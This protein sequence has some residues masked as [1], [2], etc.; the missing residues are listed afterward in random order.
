MKTSN[1]LLI[2]AVLIIIVS[3]VGYDLALRAEYRKGTYK[4]RFYGFDKTTAFSGFTKIDNRAANLISIEVEHG[5]EPGI[6]MKSDWKDRIK[7]SKIG[8]TLV[9]EAA[10][11]QAS[12]LSPYENSITIVCSSL[13]QVVTKPYQTSKSEEEEISSDGKITIKGFD[14]R[15]LD[16]HI[17]KGSGVVLEKNKIEQLQALVGDNLSQNATL[18]INSNNQINTATIKVLGRNGLRFENPKITKK[19]FIISDSA[20]VSMGGKFLNQTEIK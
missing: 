2:A 17:A 6:W 13:E 12:N 18:T 10:D 5:N 4:S 14:L 15:S 3:M 1:K 9:I 16:L 7:I 19:D 11:K 20:T 8:T